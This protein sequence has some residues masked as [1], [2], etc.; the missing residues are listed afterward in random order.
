MLTYAPSN[1][2]TA[3]FSFY[4]DLVADYCLDGNGILHPSYG[5]GTGLNHLR[6]MVAHTAHTKI[7]ESG[8]PVYRLTP[9]NRSNIRSNGNDL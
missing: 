7:T 1:D 2:Y 8:V 5:L 6:R 9:S 4:E 3:P